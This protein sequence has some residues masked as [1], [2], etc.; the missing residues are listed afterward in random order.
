[1]RSHSKTLGPD[2]RRSMVLCYTLTRDTHHIPGHTPSGTPVLCPHCTRK[3]T[4]GHETLGPNDSKVLVHM[5]NVGALRCADH[6]ELASGNASQY[7]THQRSNHSGERQQQQRRPT[8]AH[9]PTLRMMSSKYYTQQH[10]QRPASETKPKHRA[11]VAC[12]GSLL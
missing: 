9:S 8:A 10:T 11:P 7:V 2:R 5:D 6:T 3:R 4:H 1:M 12:L